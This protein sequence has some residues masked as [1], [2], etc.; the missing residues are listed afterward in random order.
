MELV[1][2]KPVKPFKAFTLLFNALILFVVTEYYRSGI[3]IFDHFSTIPFVSNNTELAT[4]EKE[5]AKLKRLLRQKAITAK[6]AAKKESTVKRKVITTKTIV[7]KKE[8]PKVKI[9]SFVTAKDS[10]YKWSAGEAVFCGGQVVSG[11]TQTAF[12]F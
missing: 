8:T 2:R 11:S 3:N 4:L 6:R 5:N 10:T 1:E 7:S 12:D 9:V